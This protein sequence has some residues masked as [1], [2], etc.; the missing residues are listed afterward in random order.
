MRLYGSSNGSVAVPLPAEQ[1]GPATATLHWM[2]RGGRLRP[3][4]QRPLQNQLVVVNLT[5]LADFTA[6]VR[7][8]S[9]GVGNG[10]G[11]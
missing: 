9:V 8:L 1:I 3:R 10:V 5:A 6:M 11:L 4:S 2:S 7:V